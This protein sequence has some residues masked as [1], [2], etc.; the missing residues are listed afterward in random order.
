MLFYNDIIDGCNISWD[1]LLHDINNQEFI[2]PNIRTT[3][4]YDIIKSIIISLYEDIEISLF[5]PDENDGSYYPGRKI[6]LTKN[7]FPS[8]KNDFLRN[9]DAMKNWK[10]N[11]YTSGTTGNPISVTHNIDTINRFLKIDEKFSD[12]IW[13]LA[14]NPNH[15]AGVQVIMQALFNG[16]TIIRLFGLSK[17]NILHQI[18]KN[19]ITH[20]SS[21]PTFYKLLCPS[22]AVFPLVERVTFGGESFNQ[23][24]LKSIKRTFPNAKATNIYASTEAGSLLASDGTFFTIK[25]SMRDFIRINSN[26]LEVHHS[27]IGKFNTNNR[28]WF[29]TGDIVK[30]KSEHPLKFEIL[31]RKSDLINV[32]GLNVNLIEVENLINSI[33]GVLNAKVKSRKNSLMGNILICDIIRS[34]SSLSEQNLK[35]YLREKLPKYKIPQIFNFVEQLNISRTGKLKRK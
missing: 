5:D 4:Y 13:G 29:K 33:E 3:N 16:N 28:M 6:Y 9:M 17:K 10:I 30:I 12:N 1:K 24:M 2:T 11:L 27:L 20:I 19:K 7:N 22:N 34:K 31:S 18:K 14:Y 21:T 23:S 15:I 35:S 32:G 8:T 26:E 25:P